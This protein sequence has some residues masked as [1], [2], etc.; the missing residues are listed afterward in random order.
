MIGLLFS[1]LNHAEAERFYEIE[2]IAFK[3]PQLW[4]AFDEQW[5][6]VELSRPIPGLKRLFSA[7]APK[8]ISTTLDELTK[9]E[10]NTIQGHQLEIEKIPETIALETIALETHDPNQQAAFKTALEPDLKP[11]PNSAEESELPVENPT[12]T[13]FTLLAKEQLQ[14]TELTEA[15]IKKRLTQNIL[16]H[17]GWI[18]QMR[19]A[20]TAVPILLEGGN[21][22]T[23][24][25]PDLQWLMG[26]YRGYFNSLASLQNDAF[27]FPKF[28]LEGTVSFYE[29]RY[30]RL[31]TNLCQT[32]DPKLLTNQ[33]LR[34]TSSSLTT[35][36]ARPSQQICSREVRGLSFGEL[37]YFDTPSFGVVIQVR[38]HQL[39]IDPESTRPG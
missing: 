37:I 31:E 23:P 38:I 32:L 36:T 13:E 29:T 26:S 11:K 33:L 6:E 28:E 12:P 16:L 35:S 10:E 4:A 19:P 18:Q 7:Q 21:P 27:N 24:S 14:L 34:T 15:L 17:T 5:P 25:R 9:N 22:L 20:N 3:Q 2:V 8:L 1:Q 39:A 30:P